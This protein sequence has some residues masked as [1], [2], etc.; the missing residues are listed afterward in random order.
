VNI[1][2]TSGATREPVDPV[3]YLSN[4][5]TGATGAALADAWALSGHEV[6]LLCGEGA[7]APRLV[8]ET[9]IFSTAEDLRERLQRRLARGS[10]DVVV[11]VAGVSD[12]RP[13]AP[14]VEK[15]SSEAQSL[16]IRFVRNPKI[17]PLLKSYAPR[18]VVVV[19]FK[20][21]VGADAV[22]RQ[23][24]VAAQF[25]A[26]GVDVVVHNDLQEIQRAPS[27]AAHPFWL[28]RSEDASPVRLDGAETLAT[29]LESVFRGR[30]A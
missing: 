5:S 29:V 6:V 20:L 2:V 23:A 12:Y 15:I 28:Y 19:G 9:E 22:A 11:M 24:A 1:L 3:R 14:P 8:R 26:G 18:P 27:A 17:V 21:T 4:G 16:T 10:F 30:M 25:A 13:E 7:A